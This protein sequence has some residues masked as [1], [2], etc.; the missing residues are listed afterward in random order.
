MARQAYADIG[1]KFPTNE[2][3]AALEDAAYREGFEWGLAGNKACPVRC[4]VG[5]VSIRPRRDCAGAG[6]D[7]RLGHRAG[8]TAFLSANGECV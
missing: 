5:N 6:V 8:Y 4:M 3:R 7:Y 2:R 1:C